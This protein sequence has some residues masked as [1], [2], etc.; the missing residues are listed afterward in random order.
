MPEVVDEFLWW[1][2]GWNGPP[3]PGCCTS[4]DPPLNSSILCR[5]FLRANALAARGLD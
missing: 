4:I 2:A 1:C 5:F 3:T